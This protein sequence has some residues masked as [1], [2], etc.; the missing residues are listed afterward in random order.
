MRSAQPRAARRR[1]PTRRASANRF[2]FC[3][4]PT[5]GHP[6]NDESHC[7]ARQLE[8]HSCCRPGRR[9]H[10]SVLDARSGS[11]NRRRRMGTMVWVARGAAVGALLM[12][13]AVARAQESSKEQAALAAALRAKHVALA[14]GLEAAVTKGKPISAKYELGD[15]KLQLSVY[16][17]KGGQFS[18][19]IVDHHTGKTA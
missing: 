3:I 17:E 11:T 9:W 10:P 18:E 7:C 8:H 15:G 19:V 6:T 14:T 2:S 5:A 16:T 12:A 4:S 1:G 13:G